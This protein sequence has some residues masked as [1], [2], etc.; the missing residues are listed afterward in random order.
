MNGI[1]TE[2]LFSKGTDMAAKIFI[3]GSE[4]TTGLRI[5]ERFA[6]R[7]YI[8]LLKIDPELR[9]DPAEIKKLINESDI[10]FLCLPDQAAV[11]AAE[12]V[13]NDRTVIIDASTAHRTLPDWAYGFPELS[14][15]HRDKIRNSRKIAVPGC[16]ASGF[17]ALAFP[18]VKEGILPK[19]YPVS[20]F[21]A[22]GY[23]GGGK[24]LIS[25][26]EEEG[27]DA[28][29]DSAR[30][31][32]WGHTHK[33]LKEMKAIP[34]LSREPLFSPFT[35]NYHSGMI[36][37]VPLFTDLLSKKV[38]PEE[39]HA[40]FE[41]YYS[42]EKFIKV[43]PFGTE[44][45]QGGAL[46]SDSCAGYDGMQIFVTGNNDRLVVA[47]RFDNLGKGAS[48]AAVQCM[49]IVLGCDEAKGLNL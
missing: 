26:Y 35:T 4:G 43:M 5:N 2:N 9:K 7:D 29:F 8:E 36:V 42:G 6:G 30:F 28:K 41:K 11:E 17:I 37:Q 14:A 46:F 18:M 48:G 40:F 21:A 45:E 20:V 44:A 22:S 34:G 33:H 49:N 32:A 25:A 39:L 27:R 23:S 31:Y 12:M 1:Y 3:D 15:E 10:T 38:T 19:D 13:D 16:Y 24:K 47:T